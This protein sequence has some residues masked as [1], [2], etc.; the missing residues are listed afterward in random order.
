MGRQWPS[1]RLQVL[2]NTAQMRRLVLTSRVARRVGTLSAM[3]CAKGG[4]PTVVVGM[5]SCACS[6][7]LLVTLVKVVMLA[8]K[9]LI[10]Q[11]LS[12]AHSKDALWTR[13]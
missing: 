10:M 3:T 13:W 1:P 9:A 12:S 7:C 2:Q 11:E 6:C 5:Q 4:Q 8:C